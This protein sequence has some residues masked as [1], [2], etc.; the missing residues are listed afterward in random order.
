MSTDHDNPADVQSSR[1][2]FCSEECLRRADSTAPRITSQDSAE[3]IPR[4][5]TRKGRFLMNASNSV[6]PCTLPNA[7]PTDDEREALLGTAEAEARDLLR[8]GQGRTGREVS[9]GRTIRHL[10]DALRR[11]VQGEPSDA[12]LVNAVATAVRKAASENLWSWD[13]LARAAL[14]AAGVASVQGDA[15]ARANS[16]AAWELNIDR[17]GGA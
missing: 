10:V 6:M 5:R 17:Q 14:R 7:V 16:D 13:D 3:P 4:V 8:S 15:A 1:A 2:S 11:T 9:A 12:H